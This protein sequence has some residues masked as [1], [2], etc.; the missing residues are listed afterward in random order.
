MT[1]NNIGD[2]ICTHSCVVKIY[3]DVPSSIFNFN[4]INTVIELDSSKRNEMGN[5][6]V[7]SILNYH[8]YT[9]YAQ[10]PPHL[11]VDFIGTHSLYSIIMNN[12][13]EMRKLSVYSPSCSCLDSAPLCVLP[14]V[15]GVCPLI[16]CPPG[17]AAAPATA[18]LQPHI[19][20]L[21]SN[22]LHSTI[23]ACTSSPII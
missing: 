5:I 1:L 7:N 15:E 14:L 6:S 23:R 4:C 16:G 22:P 20:T 18:A 19:L 3:Q 12:S 9:F 17:A 10:I 13:T 21:H 8:S 11:T 2:S